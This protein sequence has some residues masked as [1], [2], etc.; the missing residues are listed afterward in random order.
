MKMIKLIIGVIVFFAAVGQV[1]AENTGLNLYRAGMDEAAIVYFKKVCASQS[2]AREKAEANYY[3]ANAFIRLGHPDSALSYFDKGL[4]E[5]PEYPYNIVGIAGLTVLKQD[6]KAAE[7]IFK[8]AISVNKKDMGVYLAVARA[9]ISQKDYE[10]ANKYIARAIKVDSKSGWPYLLKGDIARLQNKLMEAATEYEQAIYFSPELIS[11]YLK[12]AAVYMSLNK[13]LALTTLQQAKEQSADFR[14]IDALLGELY[15][16]QGK[17]SEA[18]ASYARFIE[19]GNYSET[20]L[21]TYALYLYMDKK[22]EE[23]LPIILPVI[24]KEPNNFVANRIYAYVKA[25]TDQTEDGLKIIEKFVN[26]APKDKL[27]ALDYVSLADEQA[28]NKL[29]RE[30]I[31]NYKKAIAIDSNRRFLY[32]NIADIYVKESEIDSSAKYYDLY[33]DVAGKEDIVVLFKY[34]RNLYSMT[35]NLDSTLREKQI[36]YLRK[37]D[38]I[39]Q[40]LSEIAPGNY[41][42]YFWRARVNSLIDMETTEGLAKPY[43]EKVV[44]IA[45][46]DA[47][48]RKRELSESYRYLGYY[49]YVQADA[50]ATAKNNAKAAKEEYLKSKEYFSKVLE[51]EPENAVATQVIEAI[52]KL[53]LEK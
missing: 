52:D 42:G 45:L 50:K 47:D 37:A 51:I 6:P 8:Q 32:Q 24:Q 16:S 11:S 31:E 4:I 14:G 19:D 48:K 39:F 1:K 36:L 30:A 9:Y 23:V 5:D 40:L 41:L 20:H 3:I 26:N 12:Y 21:L 25:K 33:A 2:T 22:Y 17:S 49:Y 38:T 7:A 46:P 35:S 44:E 43:Y 27:I 34:G 53:N 10:N 15:F 18:V 29:N 28:E 13:E